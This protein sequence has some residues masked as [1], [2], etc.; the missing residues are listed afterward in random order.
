MQKAA[1]AVSDAARQADLIGQ[2]ISRV[3]GS[4][5]SVSETAGKVA[6]NP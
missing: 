3:A 2:Q 1:G 4:V 6:K 5:E